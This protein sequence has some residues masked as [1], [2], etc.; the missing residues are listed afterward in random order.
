M[1]TA[2]GCDHA[3]CTAAWL[4]ATFAG[5]PLDLRRV[6]PDLGLVHVA[7]IV[8]AVDGGRILNEKT[9]TSQI[10]GGTV[11]GI[12]MAL[13]EETL[14]TRPTA[15]SPTATWPTTASRSTL[16]SRAGG[17]LRRRTRPIQPPWGHGVGEM[18]S[19]QLAS[20]RRVLS[21]G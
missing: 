3:G 19:P 21:R 9:A 20:D 10:I 18:W 11:G 14:P 2:S 4:S 5:H 6:D 16:T 12:G 1:T 7:R 8:S 17:V 13:L 15:A